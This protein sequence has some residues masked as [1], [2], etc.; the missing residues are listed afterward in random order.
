MLTLQKLIN[1][2]GDVDI[3]RAL[4]LCHPTKTEYVLARALE[5]EAAD[6]A[7]RNHLLVRQI[8]RSNPI[9]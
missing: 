6:Q 9:E 2:L 8:R 7:S 1:G 5:Y 4:R 3:Q